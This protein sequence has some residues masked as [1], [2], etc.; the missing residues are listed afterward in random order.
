MSWHRFLGSLRAGRRDVVLVADRGVVRCPAR[1]DMAVDV[2]MA[3]PRFVAYN[4][5]RLVCHADRP[6]WLTD[7]IAS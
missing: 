1:G 2:C 5:Q 7:I 4:G 3:C 6:A